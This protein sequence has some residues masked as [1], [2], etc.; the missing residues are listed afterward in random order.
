MTGQ[1]FDRLQLPEHFWQERGLEYYDQC[2]FMKGGLV[3][4]DH[5]TTVSPTY[6]GRFATRRVGWGWRVC[7]VSVGSAW[8]ASS[9]AST[10]YLEPVQRPVSGTAYDADSLDQKARNKSQLQH[11][12]GLAPRED[13]PLLGF[14]GRLVEQ[15]GLELILPVL[16]QMLAMPAQLVVLGTGESVY[17]QRLR[18]WL[19]RGRIPWLWS[20]P[21]MSLWPITS[22]PLRI[23]S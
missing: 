14:V 13:C 9:T 7:S 5:I 16:E 15:K 1:T 4:A 21:I 17:E 6:A 12:L 18:R 10:T 11:D 8:W 3:F 23:F 19:R 2:S 20:W 22:K